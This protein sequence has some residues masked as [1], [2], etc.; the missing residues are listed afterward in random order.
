MYDN[1]GDWREKKHAVKVRSSFHKYMRIV[2]ITSLV[3]CDRLVGIT[4]Y[5]LLPPPLVTPTP[6][7]CQM[8][9]M[10]G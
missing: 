5:P 6:C 9:S 3:K 10:G 4:A 7:F 2:I 8:N 1:D